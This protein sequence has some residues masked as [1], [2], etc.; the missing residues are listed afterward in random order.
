[1]QNVKEMAIKRK[2]YHEPLANIHIDK[3]TTKDNYSSTKSRFENE[4]EW[5]DHL[6]ECMKKKVYFAFKV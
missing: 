6:L 1:M 5:L 3:I 2:I 4:S